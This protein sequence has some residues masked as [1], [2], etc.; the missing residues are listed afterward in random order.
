MSFMA[1]SD[2]ST[3]VYTQMYLRTCNCPKST[4]AERG[5]RFP[6]NTTRNSTTVSLLESFNNLE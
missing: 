5:N 1:S 4:S 2:R 3:Y 6:V